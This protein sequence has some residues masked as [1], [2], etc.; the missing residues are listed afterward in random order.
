[1]RAA[2]LK[3]I[4]VV[5][6]HDPGPVIA[7]VCDLGI[8]FVYNRRWPLGQ[9]TSLQAA[10]RACPRSAGGLL[11]TLV[12]Q[13][14]I[15]PSTIRQMAAEHRRRPRHILVASFRRRA[16]HPVVFPWRFFRDLLTAPPE[17]GARA[18]LRRRSSARDF[19]AV[20]D[21]AVV[22]DV[23]TRRQYSLLVAR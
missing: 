22:R 11:V 12:D 21:P 7:H 9:I 14:G 1:M 5:V 15:R 4:L 8:R 3:Q 6:G 17:E 18:V 13:P 10:I 20:M 19:V 23:D 16:G 2:G